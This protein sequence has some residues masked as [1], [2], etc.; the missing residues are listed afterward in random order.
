[1]KRIIIIMLCVLTGMVSVACN[2]KKGE[3]A[4]M[5]EAFAK[6][7]IEIPDGLI[8]V[9]EG[10]TRPVK[11]KKD[12][13]KM[14]YWFD[15]TQC[16]MCN[17]KRLKTLDSL[18]VLSETV[19]P[20]DILLVFSPKTRDVKTT[21]ETMSLYDLAHPVL[22][23]VAQSFIQSNPALVNYPFFH[24]FYVDKNGHPRFVGDPTSSDVMRDLFI[25]KIHQVK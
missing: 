2:E 22:V 1:M 19:S 10:E 23:D 4:Q 18:Y 24:Q 12:Q 15:S 13:P 16:S 3:L 20:F 5:A 8:Q 9:Y 17:A 25:S 21:L 14:I 11:I 7:K 6:E